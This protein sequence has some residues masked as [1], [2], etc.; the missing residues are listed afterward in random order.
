[1]QYLGR[2]G[3]GSAPGA[4]GVDGLCPLERPADDPEPPALITAF[5]KKLLSALVALIVGV[6]LLEAVAR[7]YLVWFAAESTLIRYGTFEQVELRGIPRRL[8]PHRYLGLYPTPGY[9]H[10]QNRH[11]S[12]GYRGEELDLPKPAGRFR[13]A[14]LGGST[15]YSFPGDDYRLSYPYLLERDLQARGFDVD[16]VNAGS[17]GWTSLESLVDFELRTL[18]VDPDLIVVYHGSNDVRTLFVW[19]AEAYRGDSSGRR[20]PVALDAGPLRWFERITLVRAYLIRNGRLESLN[21]LDHQMARGPA[22]YHAEDFAR[23]LVLGTYPSG[24]FA[25]TSAAEMLAANPPIYYRRNLESLVALAEAHGVESCLLTFATAPEAPRD[26]LLLSPEGAA[27]LESL[28]QIT[29]D[30]ARERGAHLFDFAQRFPREAENFVDSQH[31]SERG[32]ALQARMIA[33]FLSSEGLVG[34]R[35][36]G[37]AAR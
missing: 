27:A 37:T 28:N 1:M 26:P 24:I 14:C 23:Q 16:V 31:F 35:P 9:V 22:T 8:S 34:E 25:E 33:D 11:N 30:V 3:R 17:L 5:R 21:S 13:I 4:T 29:R 20:G 15:T 32:T 19:P 12:L 7:V 36:A 18:D 10:G 2:R 6:V